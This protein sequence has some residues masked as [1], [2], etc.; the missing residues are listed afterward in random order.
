MVELR[1]AEAEADAIIHR[2][3]RDR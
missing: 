2:R 1:P 3:W